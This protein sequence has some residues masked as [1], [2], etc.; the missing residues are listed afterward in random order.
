M[1]PGLAGALRGA[2]QRPA[3]RAP[4]Q[5]ERPAPRAPERPGPGHD[6]LVIRRQ[7]PARAR[8]PTQPGPAQPACSTLRLRSLKKRL[9]LHAPCLMPLHVSIPSMTGPRPGHADPVR[10]LKSQ[11]VLIIML[12]S[13]APHF[14]YSAPRPGPGRSFL[15]PQRPCQPC[16]ERKWCERLWQAM[17]RVEMRKNRLT[18]RAVERAAKRQCQKDE[19][20][21]KALLTKVRDWRA[22]V[23]DPSSAESVARQAALVKECLQEAR[24]LAKS[25]GETLPW[26]SRKQAAGAVREAVGAVRR[27]RQQGGH[28]GH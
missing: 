23:F 25:K 16:M 18:I 28:R 22:H 12:P 13:S 14:F 6:A 26:D 8:S 7:G 19:R 10:T 5:N 17:P 3:P 1:E 21:T 9:L 11:S 24:A 20:Q 2:D 4:G 27:Q 15:A